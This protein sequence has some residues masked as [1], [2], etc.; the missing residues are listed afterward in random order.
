MRILPLVISSLLAGACLAQ[1]SS[2]QSAALERYQQGVVHWMAG[3]R[4]SALLDFEAALRA[5]PN[6]YEACL[7]IG[8]LNLQS[9]KYDKARKA[10]ARAQT[11]R[12]EAAGA[13]LGLGHVLWEAE[14]NYPGALEEYR[15][16]LTLEPEN[17]EANYF[18][19]HALVFEEKYDEARAHLEKAIQ[20]DPAYAKPHE[21]LA[22]AHMLQGRNEQAAQHWRELKRKG[23]MSQ[24]LVEFNQNLLMTVA[25]NGI[26]ITNGE[27][28]TYPL[29][30]LQMSEGVRRDVSVVN[31]GLLNFTWYVRTL[32]EHEPKLG[33][34]YDDDYL[35]ERLQERY[36]PKP[37]KAEIAGLRWILPPA[38]GYK[39]L[40]VQDVVLLDL[41]TWNAWQRPVYFAV[42]LA[43]E[44]KLGLEDFLTMEGLAW[45]LHSQK[46]PA[47]QADSTW[48]NVRKR[49]SYVYCA[50][51][52]DGASRSLVANYATVFCLLADAYLQR[53]DRERCHA[54]LA[55]ADSLGVLQDAAANRW[56]AKLA[57]SIA[58]DELAERFTR[59]AELLRRN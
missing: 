53:R 41:L 33:I 15:R 45:R 14:Q 48:T 1:Q 34:R 17:A 51:S 3:A 2:V 54:T 28:D 13:H 39:H 4:D 21:K 46:S 12:P 20:R 27:E 6:Y 31:L 7:A 30:Y 9:A 16:A 57:S 26:L 18:V 55:W 49:Y 47:I 24:A 56:A 35:R 29:W 50:E 37:A 42:T 22:L 32:R 19:G 11:L 36:W 44:N 43:P 23:G 25:Q 8:D 58:S 5:A 10:Y 40:R 38:P 52:S 59:K